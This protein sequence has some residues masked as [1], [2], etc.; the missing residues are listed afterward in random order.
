MLLKLF[1]YYGKLHFY[2]IVLI[3]M[4]RVLLKPELGFVRGVDIFITPL[5][6]RLNKTELAIHFI[7]VCLAV[8]IDL[9]LF[10]LVRF[11]WVF[12]ENN[13]LD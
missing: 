3:F 7:L 1:V 4:R 12:E 5:I 6:N 9:F 13:A 8:S 11:E 2:F 10:L